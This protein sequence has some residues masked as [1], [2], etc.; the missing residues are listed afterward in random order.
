MDLPDLEFFA[1]KWGWQYVFTASSFCTDP[2]S[3]RPVRH[4]VHEKSIQRAVKTSICEAGILQ[5]AS[6]H[7]FRSETV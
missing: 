5:P 2:Y 3:G 1:T 6:C 7:T 4:Q